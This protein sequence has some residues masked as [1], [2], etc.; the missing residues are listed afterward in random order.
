MFECFRGK[1]TFT[2]T[3]P[4][5]QYFYL[6]REKEMNTSLKL[7]FLLVK[8]LVMTCA[9]GNGSSFS[10]FLRVSFSLFQH[11]VFLFACLFTLKL[12]LFGRSSNNNFTHRFWCIQR[13]RCTTSSNWAFR[14][15]C[16]MKKKL[17]QVKTS[18][19]TIYYESPQRFACNFQFNWYRWMPDHKL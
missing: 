17:R 18:R 11:G 6:R 7:H 2:H 8:C 16:W 9:S 3:E 10:L 14:I 12:K 1:E 13:I 5:F 4:N 15:R 19:H